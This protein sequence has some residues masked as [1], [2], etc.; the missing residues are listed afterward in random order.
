[1]EQY[2]KELKEIKSFSFATVDEN[3]KPKNR[4]F[5]IMDIDAQKEGLYFLTSKHKKV[6]NQIMN[7]KYV[8]L[9]VLTPNYIDYR[10]EGEVV[11]EGDRDYLLQSNPEVLK[12]YK[13]NTEVLVPFFVKITR[14]T[15][16]DISSEKPKFE[17][18]K[19]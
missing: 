9:S 12:M 15:K 1:M 17:I 4:I 10:I 14:A 5:D 2:L 19:K 16:F 18:I 3:N 8:A 7:N 6:Y 13:D 11:F